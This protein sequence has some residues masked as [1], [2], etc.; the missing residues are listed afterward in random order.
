[1][2]SGSKKEINK[3][4]NQEINGPSAL[5]LGPSADQE[6]VSNKNS[7]KTIILV[8]SWSKKESKKSVNQEPSEL[9][10]NF[11]NLII[12][13]EQRYPASHRTRKM[14]MHR[15]KLCSQ[16]FQ[17]ILHFSSSGKN[18]LKEPFVDSDDSTVEVPFSSKK[19]T[20]NAFSY[21][22][23]YEGTSHGMRERANKKDKKMMN[24]KKTKTDYLIQNKQYGFNNDEL[25]VVDILFN[26]SGNFLEMRL[27]TV[28]QIQA[29]VPTKYMFSKEASKKTVSS[30]DSW[31]KKEIK[32]P[33]NQERNS[34]SA[35]NSGLS[36]DQESV[37]NK[38]SKKTISSVDSCPRKNQRNQS[39]KNPLNCHK[40][41]R[42]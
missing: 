21:C 36:A 5:N 6:W 25:Q 41:S 27:Q 2:D 22:L 17:S 28:L 37:S 7:K 15:A 34:P 4:V 16:W 29:P 38:N 11:K 33:V 35:M 9:P 40:I 10:Q 18:K 14:E 3:P 30:I 19:K 8:D 1:M 42:T 24:I 13:Q 39:T 23:E 31:S 12:G 32:K 26:L 20:A